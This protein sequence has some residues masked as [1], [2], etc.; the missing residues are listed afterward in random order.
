[1]NKSQFGIIVEQPFIP[2]CHLV[3][4]NFTR[5]LLNTVVV[6]AREESDFN[7]YA[8]EKGIIMVAREADHA[9]EC[10]LLT[11]ACLVLVQL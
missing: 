11:L 2:L 3:I 1:M 4:L 5:L 8:S 6:K 7:E 10:V 9:T